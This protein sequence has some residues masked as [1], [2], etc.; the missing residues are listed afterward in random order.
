MYIITAWRYSLQEMLVVA[1]H[2][3]IITIEAQCVYK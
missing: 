1:R 3:D 2:T